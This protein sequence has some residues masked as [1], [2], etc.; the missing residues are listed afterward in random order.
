MRRAEKVERAR[1]FDRRNSIGRS[2]LFQPSHGPVEH[3]QEIAPIGLRN[4]VKSFGRTVV[5]KEVS[6]ELRQGEVLALLGENGAGKSTCVKLLAGVHTP[7]MGSV[8][9]DGMPA[10]F[11]SPADASKAGVAVMHQHP[12]LFPDL[13]IAENIFIG[14]MPTTG[15]GFIDAGRMREEARRVLDTVGLNVPPETRL[16]ELRTSEQ[17]LVE[18][19]RALSLKA[20]VLIMDEPTAA[21]SQ[22]EVERLFQ[23]VGELRKQGVAMMFVGHRMDEIFRIADRIAVLR[24]G[25][26]VGVE[27]AAALSRPAAIKMMVGRE[28]SSLY[29]E[30]TASRGPVSLAVRSLVLQAGGPSIDL[31]VRKGEIVGLGGLVG[32]G[33]TEIARVLFGVDRPVSGEIL[34]DGIPRKIHSPREA[35]DAGIAYVSED[36]MG[37]SLVMDFSILDNAA[38]TVLAK[39]AH[40]GFYRPQSAIE[41]VGGE[42][43]RMK[44]R[45]SGYEQPVKQLSG[46]NQQKVVISK[47]LATKPRIFILDEPTQGI[48]VNTKAEIHAMI[49]DLAAQGMAIILISSELPELL[50]MC[51]RIIVLREGEKT[52]EFT[53][54]EATQELILEAAT[55][56]RDSSGHA[57]HDR[58]DAAPAFTLANILK[59]REFGLF[60]A[61]AA[62]ILPVALINPRIFSAANLT[63]VSMDVALLMV[64]ALGQMLVLITRNIDLSVASIIGLAAYLS[65]SALSAHP[66]IGPIGGLFIACSVGIAA[67]LINGALVTFGRIPAIVVT[68]GTLSI[69]R[70]LNSLWAAGDQVSADEVPISWLNMT[71]TKLAG[72]PLIVVVTL[73]ILLTAS[74][75]LNNTGIGRELFATGSNPDGAELVGIPQRRRILLAFA[76]AGLLAGICGALWASRYATVDARVATGFELT[77]IAASV[78]GGVAIRG[79]AGTLL[80]VALGAL[81]LLVIKNGLTLV[82]VDP[83]WLQGVYGLVILAAIGIDALVT[84]RA[85][86]G[87]N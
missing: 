38:L 13:S 20:R 33:R 59:R 51:D 53:R 31:I 26:L 3:L 71:G 48:D 47:W 76:L 62:V 74:Y 28:L 40:R 69:Y 42:L 52:A 79:G 21:L 41:L 84:R 83:L 23:V 12:G 66:A 39:A 78:V 64:A 58:I 4:A 11:Q 30:R 25:S 1:L 87:N 49:A 7:T 46:G 2:I 77:I 86:A 9:V 17:Q 37:Q 6:F 15:P 67:G 19:A 75:L 45:F 60:A 44:L 55:S 32:S 5:L 85:R 65:A 61:M 68:L 56:E 10:D 27:P 36:R 35:M 72:V 73:L 57:E 54:E 22:R 29:P 18:I 50:G 81:T 43:Q 14:H 16:G 24:D 70:G 34:I 8:V 63:A 80:G 82:R